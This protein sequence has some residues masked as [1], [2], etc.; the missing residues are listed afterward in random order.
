MRNR[1]IM[2]NRELNNIL[3]R[4][5]AKKED[6]F[7]ILG[8][9]VKANIVMGINEITNDIYE[10]STKI[11]EIEEE[12]VSLENINIKEVELNEGNKRGNRGQNN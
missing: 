8:R 1:G 10:I 6:L 3:L 9:R 11:D 5:Y 4:T 7:K 2:N 12:I